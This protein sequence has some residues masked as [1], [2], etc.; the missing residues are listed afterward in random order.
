MKKLLIVGFV[1][2]ISMNY[3]IQSS[4]Y[5]RILA[6]DLRK[7]M[8]A[9]S[10]V[11]NRGAHAHSSKENQDSEKIKTWADFYNRFLKNCF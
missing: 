7:K 3:C 2:I 1:S 4:D 8:V 6:D 9:S 10:Q 5:Q 11:E